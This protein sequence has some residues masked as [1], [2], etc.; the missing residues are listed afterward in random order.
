M[1]HSLHPHVHKLAVLSELVDQGTFQAACQSTRLSQS[2][3]SQIVTQLESLFGTTLVVRDK[4]HVSPTPAGADLVKRIRPI[5]LSLD[6]LAPRTM[7]T[8]TCPIL[9]RLSLGTY[10]SIA[11]DVLPTLTKKLRAYNPSLDLQ[12]RT[13]RSS[14]LCK[15]VKKG[16]LSMAVVV[17]SDD[18][19][20]VDIRPLIKDSLGLFVSSESGLAARG[21]ESLKEIG[22]GTMAS[23]KNGYPN[24]YKRYIKTLERI[25]EP[26]LV[27]DSFEALR[28]VAAGGVMAAV[29]PVRVAKRLPD[30]GLTE[31]VVPG[32]SSGQH[33]I[34]LISRKGSSPADGDFLAN[35]LRALLI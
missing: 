35:E 7:S 22:Y 28:A 34:V 12:L 19:K 25:A 27:S 21:I 13:G 20:G 14:D 16:E 18:I 26:S 9:S 23:N 3:I 30:L 2:A 15:L 8:S 11:I 17:E 29:L 10:E 1:N 31:I 5:L 32:I 33:R 24:Y 6:E 4:G